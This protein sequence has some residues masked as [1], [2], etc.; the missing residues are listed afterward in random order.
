MK[1]PILED[2]FHFNV[3]EIEGGHFSLF[4]KFILVK[5][6]LQYLSIFDK[7]NPKYNNGQI[8]VWHWASPLY[9]LKGCKIDVFLFYF[10][11]V[12]KRHQDSKRKQSYN[13]STWQWFVCHKLQGK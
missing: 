2:H 3:P 10:L 8:Q 7:D 11:S 9:N 4:K 1:F 13:S 5:V 6:R 12:D